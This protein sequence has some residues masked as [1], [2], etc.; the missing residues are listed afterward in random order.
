MV[1]ASAHVSVQLSHCHVESFLF[2]LLAVHVAQHL[3]SVI[4]ESLS[5]DLVRRS[6]KLPLL[7]V[8]HVSIVDGARALDGDV[9]QLAV[10]FTRRI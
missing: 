10:A 4:H 5:V 7:V 1:P 2:V 3:D 6:C 9:V 8:V